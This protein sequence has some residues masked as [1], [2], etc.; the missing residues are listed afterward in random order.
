MQNNFKH[1]Q[2]FT[3]IEILIVVAIIGILSGVM[4]PRISFYFEPPQTILTRS[5]EEAGNLALRG[6]PV[7]FVFKPET[8]RRRGKILVEALQKAKPEENSLSAFLGTQKQTE[9]LE[10]Q[11]YKLSNMPEGEFWRV[12][13]EIIYFY[14]DGS[15]TPAKISYAE[16]GIS[17][18]QAEIFILTV[19]GYCFKQD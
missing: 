6:V 8:S 4:L 13:P 14:T 12:E 1:H 3:L 11:E 15:C 9:I 10:W 7:R 18:S 16:N 2:G 19:T 17:E 5:L